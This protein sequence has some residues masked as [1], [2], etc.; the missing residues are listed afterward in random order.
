[1]T[2]IFIREAPARQIRPAH[3]AR[4][5]G[6]ESLLR[7]VRLSLA[8]AA[9]LDLACAKFGVGRSVLL[10]TLIADGLRNLEPA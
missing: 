8:D 5:E 2:A 3:M 9:A 4:T 7:T 1:M 6:H 10:R